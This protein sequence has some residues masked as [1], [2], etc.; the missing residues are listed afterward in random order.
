MGRWWTKIVLDSN[1]PMLSTPQADN[2][3]PFTEAEMPKN[4][5][6]QIKLRMPVDLKVWVDQQAKMNRSSKGSEIVRCV[7][8]RKDR[9]E[10]QQKER[11]A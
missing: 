8:E 6:T 1:G 5:D 2:I 4:E 11:A 7:R 3:G 9:V 10:Q